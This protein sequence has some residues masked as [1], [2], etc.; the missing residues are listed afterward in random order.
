MIGKLSPKILQ[1]MLEIL[2]VEFSVL[3]K[4]D[5][6]NKHGTR[7]FKRP[8]KA[9]RKDVRKCHPKKSLAKV[10]E[11]LSEM[12]NGLRDNAVFWIDLEL[13]PGENPQKILIE[14]FALRDVN[15]EYL[16]CL[17]A[18]QNITG[19]QR[20]TGEKRLMDANPQEPPQRL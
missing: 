10:E 7:I 18:T 20:I 12:K 2:P 13:S 14:Y 19:H 4:D 17:E 16:G 1:A 6:W 9:L 8:E 11:L 3:D 5:S 15:G